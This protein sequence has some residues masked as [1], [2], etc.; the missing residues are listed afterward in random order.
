MWDTSWARISLHTR[1]N[2]PAFTDIQSDSASHQFSGN[3][4]RSLDSGR[5]RALHPPWP[6]RCMFS[7]EPNAPLA[8]AHVRVPI[9]LPD[10][11][12]DVATALPRVVRPRFC[13]D[14]LEMRL[15][16]RLHLVHVV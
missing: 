6:A 16:T 15:Q 4:F 10:V 2:P 14:R 1:G 8:P 7:G 13:D 5:D 9:L 12:H 3:L 11:I